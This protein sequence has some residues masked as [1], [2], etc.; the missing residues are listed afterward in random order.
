MFNIE[1]LKA[2]P[3]DFIPPSCPTESELRNIAAVLECTSRGLLPSQYRSLERAE[4]IRRANELAA[5]VWS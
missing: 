4:L 1:D 2:V 5:L 3:D